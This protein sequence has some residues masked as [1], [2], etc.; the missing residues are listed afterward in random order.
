MEMEG[1]I[2]QQHT[3]GKAQRKRPPDHTDREQKRRKDS[4]S[5]DQDSSAIDEIGREVKRCIE[6]NIKL[7]KTKAIEPEEVIK[8]LHSRICQC[9]TQTLVQ[10]LDNIR[11]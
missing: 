8:L 7:L 10:Q 2:E 6:V 1:S 3:L 9:I 11:E 4:D 5:A